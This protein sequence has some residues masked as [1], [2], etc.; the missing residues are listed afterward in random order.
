MSTPKGTRC[1]KIKLEADASIFVY[2]SDD[3]LIMQTRRNV[4]T[5]D[6]V[7][8]PSFKIAVPLQPNE[9][10]ELAGELLCAASSQLDRLRNKF[11]K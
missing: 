9:A 4:A 11:K 8:S 5:E 2:S 10:I 6:D 7:L 3:Q 1:R